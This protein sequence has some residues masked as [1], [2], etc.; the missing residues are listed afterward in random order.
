MPSRPMLTTPARSDHKPARPA[1]AIGTAE[2][3]AVWIA[4]DDVRSVAP[5]NSRITEI[6]ASPAAT[7]TR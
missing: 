2:A 7:I 6:T 5:E 1:R 3:I 4:P